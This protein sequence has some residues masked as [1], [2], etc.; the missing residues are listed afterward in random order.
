[1]LPEVFDIVI[2]LVRP[3]PSVPL[4]SI[5]K[6]PEMWADPVNGNPTWPSMLSASI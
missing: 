5:L 2:E 1:M 4:W 3:P 6:L